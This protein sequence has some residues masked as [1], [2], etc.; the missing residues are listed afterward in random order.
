MNMK[1]QGYNEALITYIMAASSTT[2][3]ISAE[4]YNQGWAKNG[5]IVNGKEFY[6]IKL[7]LGYDYG[8]PL[9]FAHYSFLGINPT[10]LSD[11]YANYWEQNR[12]HTLINREYCIQNPKDY[13]GYSA[14][15]WGLTASDN[16]DGYSAQSPTN[17]LGVITPT[18]ALSS[19]P[20]APDE[21]M[22]ALRFFY[23]QLG[24]RLWGE[25]G[26]YDAFNVTESWTA[27]SYLAIDQGP[28]VVMIENYRTG[29]VW[30]LLMS[31][32][33]VKAGLTKLGFTY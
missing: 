24:D 22:Q 23:Y 10:N 17:D 3:P 9:F 7:P 21:S 32:P 26:F 8:G 13:V 33:E 16:Q 2:H 11:Q 25:Y 20:F 4:V 14:D 27:G 1:I 19:L 18:A 15:C 30:N 12:N 5:S 31:C 29:L 6:G 28:I